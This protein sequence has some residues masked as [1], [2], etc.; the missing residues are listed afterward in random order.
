MQ[1]GIEITAACC[2]LELCQNN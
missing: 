1:H 2:R